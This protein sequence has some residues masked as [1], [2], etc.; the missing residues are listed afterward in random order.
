[1]LSEF[2]RRLTGKKS[3]NKFISAV[4]E[5]KGTILFG[6]SDG[7]LLQIEFSDEKTVRIS[8]PVSPL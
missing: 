3:K 5:Y 2:T 8:E 1:M 4:A 7:A 6:F